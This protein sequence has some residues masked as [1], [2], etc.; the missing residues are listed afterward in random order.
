MEPKT[1]RRGAG[2]RVPRPGSV[3]AIHNALIAGTEVFTLDGTLPVEVLVPGDRVITRDAGAVALREVRHRH[4]ALP[5]VRLRAG[6]LG[7][8]RPD[9]DLVM[10]ARQEI[11]V[12][13]WRASALFGR[14]QAL[15][16]ARRLCD[17]EFVSEIGT[18]DV[19]V[20]ELVFDA[21]HIVYADGLEVAAGAPCPATVA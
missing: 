19:S 3:D 13:D 11:L 9:R 15:V 7:N 6:S 21:P 12:R 14:A 20:V 18:C 4:A 17:G 5:L 10:P 8:A 16:A 1:V 2:A